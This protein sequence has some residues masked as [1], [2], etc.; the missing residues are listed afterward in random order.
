MISATSSTS[1]DYRL[2]D[3]DGNGLLTDVDITYIFG[4]WGRTA[5]QSCR[6]ENMYSEYRI[7]L[8]SWK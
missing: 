7:T 4:H 2:L 8:R 6:L 5:N 3:L 1:F